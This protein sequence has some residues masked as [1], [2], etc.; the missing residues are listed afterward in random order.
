METHSDVGGGEVHVGQE[1]K[2]TKP[3]MAK[4]VVRTGG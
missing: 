2:P 4:V 3:Q 1:K